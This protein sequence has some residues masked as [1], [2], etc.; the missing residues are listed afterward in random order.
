MFHFYD[1]L[2]QHEVRCFSAPAVISPFRRA[3]EGLPP[4]DFRLKHVLPL[5]LKGTQTCG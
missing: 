3:E 1:T 4:W 5:G 2:P